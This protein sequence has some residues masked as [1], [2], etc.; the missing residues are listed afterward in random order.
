[1]N[2]SYT[3]NIISSLR[4]QRGLTQKE[5]AAL[6]H[7][8]DKAVSKWERGK[9]FPDL[10]LLQPLAEVLGVSVSE[11]LG[12]EEE[13]SSEAIA[14][15]SAISHQEKRSIKLSLYVFFGTSMLAS[16]L[17]FVFYLFFARIGYPYEP[18][19][20]VSNL[21]KILLTIHV[22]LIVNG[23]ITLERLKKKLSSHK[24]FHWPMDNNMILVDYIKMQID[25]WRGRHTKDSK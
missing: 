21:A 3:G 5:L 6:L 20:L 25:L 7:V 18:G 19:L 12:T 9:N 1:M 8:T 24:D 15:I 17:F 14:V 13:I 4:K 2:A 10:L 16:I 11:L 22:I 23:S